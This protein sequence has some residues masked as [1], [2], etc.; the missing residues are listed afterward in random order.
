MPVQFKN[1]TTGGL[2]E[3][4]GRWFAGIAGAMAVF[5]MALGQPGTATAQEGWEWE[6]DEGYHEEEWY[7][8][9]DWF[10]D[11]STVDYE[12]DWDDYGYGYNDYAY[13]EYDYGEGY[14]DDYGY[15]YDDDWYYTDDWYEDE[16]VFDTWYD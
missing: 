9:S 4:L 3:R 13:D 14:Y 1:E 16:G 10:D 7:D 12:Y 5:L 2:A 8:P 11:D 15:G 6:P